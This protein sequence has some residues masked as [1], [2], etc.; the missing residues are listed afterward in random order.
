MFSMRENLGSDMRSLSRKI[1]IMI[2]N[3][4][5]ILVVTKVIVLNKVLLD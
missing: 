1:G 4:M 5:E 3:Q 2:H